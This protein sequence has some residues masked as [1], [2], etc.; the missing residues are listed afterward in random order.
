MTD[1]FLDIYA[2]GKNVRKSKIYS[3]MVHQALNTLTISD[4]KEHGRRSRVVS[5]G[6]S[7]LAMRNYEP[8]M[9]AIIQRFYGSLLQASEEEKASSLASWKPARNVS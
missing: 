7:D 2:Q 6:F 3:A 8:S 9:K 4:P 5:Q 1:T